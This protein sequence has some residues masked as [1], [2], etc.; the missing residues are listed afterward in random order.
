MREVAEASLAL[1]DGLCN[2]TIV[3]YPNAGWAETVF[4]EPDVERL[5]EAV[6]P[7]GTPRR[8]RSGRRPGASTSTGSRPR[9]EVLNDAPL[10]PAALPRARHRPDDRPARGVGLAGGARRVARHQARREHADR[11][12]LHHPRRAPRRGHGALDLAAP[13]PGQHRP[14]ARGAIRGRPRR[15]GARRVGRGGDAR[16]H[17]DRRRRRAPRRGRARRR[18]LARRPDRARLL[19]HALRR[20]RLVAHRPRH[21]DRAGRP[22]GVRALPGGATTSAASTTRRSTPTS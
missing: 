10:R 21:V 1:T 16:A 9:A 14:R 11:G 2:W 20:E 4:G 22:V 19:R 13:D 18:P 12:G 7:G 3:A 17:H 6:A 15:R 8:A 5:W